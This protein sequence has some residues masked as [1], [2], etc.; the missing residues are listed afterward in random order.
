MKHLCKETLKKP[1]KVK[2]CIKAVLK[3]NLCSS[4]LG[5]STL[6]AAHKGF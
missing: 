4:S 3:I 6:T 2:N 1:V 5:S